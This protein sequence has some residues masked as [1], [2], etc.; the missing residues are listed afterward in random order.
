LYLD[1]GG[2]NLIFYTGKEELLPENVEIF[3]NT[4]VCIILGRPKLSQLI[5]NIIY[6]IESGRGL[7]EQYVPEIRRDAA[8]LLADYL[9][10]DATIHTA[11]V[12]GISNLAA[13]RGFQITDKAAVLAQLALTPK[14]DSQQRRKSGAIFDHLEF[15]FK[16]WEEHPEAHSFVKDL[17]KENIIP[18]WGMLYC[19]GAKV[20]ENELQTISD[21]YHLDLHIE[22]FGW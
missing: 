22:S 11:A 16:P 7:P 13:E 4:N 12:E 1:H 2:W 17:S 6:G 19:G 15:S 9:D 10:D 21:K 5:P 20:L 18:T 3:T 8:E 14:G